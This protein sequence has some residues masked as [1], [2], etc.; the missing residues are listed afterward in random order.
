[1]DGKIS[2][3][4][5]KTWGRTKLKFGGGGGI[6]RGRLAAGIRYHRTRSTRGACIIKGSITLAKKKCCSLLEGEKVR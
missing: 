1:M 6:R 5:E 2:K 4:K 3:E